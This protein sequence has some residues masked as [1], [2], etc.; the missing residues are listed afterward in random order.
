MHNNSIDHC[1]NVSGLGKSMVVF[2]LFEKLRYSNEISIKFESL[3]RIEAFRG[4]K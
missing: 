4:G 3:P 1:R 2:H